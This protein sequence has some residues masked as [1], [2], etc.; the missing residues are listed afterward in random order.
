MWAMMGKE[1]IVV[2]IRIGCAGADVAAVRG[3]AP[4]LVNGQNRTLMMRRSSRSGNTTE[5]APGERRSRTGRMLPD[6]SVALAATAASVRWDAYL[7]PGCWDEMIVDGRPRRSCAGVAGY[8]A[9]L[10][11]GELVERQRSAELAIEARGITFTVYSEAGNIDRAWPFDVIPRVIEAAEWDA[12][13]VGLTQ[14]LEARTCS[15]TTCT[16]RRKSFATGYF[17]R[18]CWRF[19]EFSDCVSRR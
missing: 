11:L 18:S 16:A 2:L 9:S 13:S 1:V 15:S 4:C 14:R 3:G 5:T 8:L 6:D 17:R 12:I 19:E 7:S 10:S